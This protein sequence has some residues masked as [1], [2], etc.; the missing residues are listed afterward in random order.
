MLT[1]LWFS[2][3]THWLIWT[4]IRYSNW[5]AYVAVTLPR[6]TKTVVIK[7]ISLIWVYWEF[8]EICVISFEISQ[9]VGWNRENVNELGEELGRLW[10]LVMWTAETA[11]FQA[12]LLVF[13]PN[14]SLSSSL[15]PS[16]NYFI[17]F[18]EH[19]PCPFIFSSNSKLLSTL[20]ASTGHLP[21]EACKSV[22]FL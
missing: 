11:V 19:L 21:K 1:L 14:K 3:F 12:S 5:L 20:N 6:K 17:L 22:L 7:G 8:N 4:I 16:C 15:F 13:H 10:R 18:S 9:V 2:M